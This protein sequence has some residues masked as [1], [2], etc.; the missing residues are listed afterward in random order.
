MPVYT[1]DSREQ[2]ALIVKKFG[3]TI[4]P[5]GKTLRGQ[6]TIEGISLWDVMTPSMA[7]YY[8]P[9]SVSL[10]PELRTLLMKVRPHLTLIKHRCINSITKARNILF[11]HDKKLQPSP[12][13]FMGFNNY[14]YNDALAPLAK[15]L[16]EAYGKHSIVLSDGVLPIGKRPNSENIQFQSTWQYWDAEL[17]KEA[18]IFKDKTDISIS[19]LDK[20]LKLADF[21]FDS[22]HSQNIIEHAFNWLLN[23]DLPLLVNQVILARRA[24][25]TCKPILLISS[26]VADIRSRVFT[27]VAK[28][29]NIPTLE[30]QYGSC[31]EYSYQWQFLL[32]EHI[33]VWGKQSRENLLKQGVLEHQMT[34]TGAGRNDCLANIDPLVVENTIV[35][36]FASTYQQKEYNS[37]SP[38]ELNSLMKKAIFNAA[39]KVQGLTL[40]VKPHPL[41]DVDET[42]SLLSSEEN[43]LFTPAST[44]IRDLI[45][46]CDVFISLG[47]TATIDAM[48]AKKIII[49]P[50]F[51]DWIWSEWLVKSNATLVPR[52]EKEIEEIFISILEDSGEEIKSELQS[53]QELYIE[54]MV[55]KPDGF[56]SNRTAQLA[57]KLAQ[58]H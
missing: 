52:S 13:M 23:F 21:S 45:N 46:V 12:Y 26:D 49:C 47:T 16:S 50:V 24:I 14:M 35:V 25:K 40:I 28:Q 39:N 18:R 17:R 10:K 38:P 43:I 22:E 29:E 19:E 51:D 37:F 54:K 27:L 1:D 36:L 30:L 55:Y 41:E 11:N 56:S 9:T 48:I 3:E 31:Q 15:S 33:A 44:D 5:N 57:M 20:L 32:A 8:V 53:N 42:R 7:L 4:L 2:S 6:L 34:V 58:T